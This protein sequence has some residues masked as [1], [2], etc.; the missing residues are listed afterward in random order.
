[1]IWRLIVVF[2]TTIDP[3]FLFLQLI[4][5]Q[6]TQDNKFYRLAKGRDKESLSNI[7]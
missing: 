3:F 2:L 5:T 4:S 7:F 6:I 1:M